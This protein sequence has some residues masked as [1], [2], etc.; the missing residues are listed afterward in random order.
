MGVLKESEKK[1]YED[2]ISFLSKKILELNKKLIESEKAKSR[3]LSLVA[4]ELNNPMTV[5]M[6]LIPHLELQKC[7]KN[8]EL[9]FLVSKELMNLDYK[10]MN[11]VAAA[12]I[13]NGKMD[14]S[15]FSVN[16]PTLIEEAIGFF[17]YMSIEKDIHFVL[18]CDFED[19]I[20]IEPQFLDI[21]LKNLIANS[22]Q[23]G[24]QH[25]EVNICCSGDDTH[26]KISITNKGKGPKIEFKPEVFTRFSVSPENEHGLGI[27]LSIVKEL[28][29]L[30]DG[31]VDYNV[32]DGFVTFEV[33]I[34]LNDKGVMAHA[35]SS[36]E[37]LFDS[38]EGAIEL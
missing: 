33:T 26:L 13:E 29:T 2:E 15:Y 30:L 32:A 36:N 18:D 20:A 1:V 12:Q 28:C 6:G 4:Y 35:C 22:C 37:F 14:I 25:S 16:L 17:K 7:D 5:L 23:Y 10:V 11:L 34:C 21:I 24:E 27:G 19:D 3:F 9:L 8:E 31:D 38:F